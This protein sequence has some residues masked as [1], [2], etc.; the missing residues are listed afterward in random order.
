MPHSF[1]YEVDGVA[2]WRFWRLSGT[3]E[4]KMFVES[5]ADAGTVRWGALG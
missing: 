2:R 3:A 4:S 5:D 1:R